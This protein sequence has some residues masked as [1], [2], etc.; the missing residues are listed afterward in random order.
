[1]GAKVHLLRRS[2]A[3][4]ERQ[5]EPQMFCRIHRSTIVHLA[6][7]QGLGLNRDGEQE[8]I[9]EDGTALRISRR[10]RKALDRRLG[11]RGSTLR[12]SH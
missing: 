3:E 2:L 12:T 6:R 11:V 1:V 8:A 9:L 7:I 4:L 5:L 10:Y